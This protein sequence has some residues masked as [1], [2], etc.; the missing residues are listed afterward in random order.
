MKGNK[1]KETQHNVEK[2]QPQKAQ[3]RQTVQTRKNDETQI[4]CKQTVHGQKTNVAEG[5]LLTK[6]S[7]IDFCKNK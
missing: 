7:G 2:Q 6:R 5:P 1:K 3:T 4:K